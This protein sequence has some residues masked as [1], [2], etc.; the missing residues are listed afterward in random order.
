MPNLA[1]EAELLRRAASEEAV[2]SAWVARHEAVACARQAG[3][4]EEAVVRGEPEE[5]RRTMAR[6]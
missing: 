6:N 5:V 3:G 2:A 4:G 1:H